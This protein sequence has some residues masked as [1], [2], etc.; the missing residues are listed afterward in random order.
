MSVTV[1]IPAYNSARTLE[2]CLRA[3]L[4]QDGVGSPEVI[5]VDDG[6]TDDTAAVAATLPVTCIR[7]PNAGPA[8]A[9]NAG[10]RAG[11]G[12]IVCFTDADCVP[13]P[14]WAAGLTAEFA[15]GPVTAVGG[16]YDYRGTDGL[17]RL[18][19]E[20]IRMR[21]R[22]M[23]EQTDVLGGYNLA[24]RR[25]ALEAVGG[26]NPEYRTASAEDNDLCYRLTAAGFRLHFAPDIRVEHLHAWRL[27]PYLKTQ[28]RHG[29]WRMKLYRDHPGRGRGDRYAGPRDLLAPPLA[30]VTLALLLARL[31]AAALAGFVLLVL[32][33][34]THS[35]GM[36]C[37]RSVRAVAR[38]FGMTAG[39]VWFIVL[40]RRTAGRT[41]DRESPPCP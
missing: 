28:A 37:L 8:A 35:A 30:M 38:G 39:T 15:R 18:I 19:D 7:Q 5:V 25:S 16:G 32:L 23:P 26:F 6:S 3:C 27:L 34:A 2:R 21:H 4:A 22:A 10:W 41:P 1:V 13:P 29:F 24:V 20:E 9:R 12:E 17:G 31:P 11:H 33:S 36:T 40:R 14:H